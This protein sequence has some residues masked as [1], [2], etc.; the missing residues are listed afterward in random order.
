MNHARWAIAIAGCFTLL[1]AAFWNRSGRTFRQAAVGP[2]VSKDTPGYFKHVYNRRSPWRTP[3]SF[4]GKV[5]DQNAN[6]I[7]GAAVQLAWNDT[8][9]SGT[10]KRFML[11]DARGEFS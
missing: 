8:S 7:E 1:A 2:A 3:I 9:A 6:P 5:I 4:Y 10:S 11:S